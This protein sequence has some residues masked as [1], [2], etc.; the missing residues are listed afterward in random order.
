MFASAVLI[1]ILAQLSPPSAAPARCVAI[2][3]PLHDVQLAFGVSGRIESI[4][5]QRGQRVKAGEIVARLDADDLEANAALL[6]LRADGTW[7]VDAATS[8]WKS[9]DDTL[10]RI[11]AARASSAA[12]DRELEE[13]THRAQQ[14]LAQLNLEK[15]RQLEATWELK[16]ALARQERTV[17]R[18]S[19]A[20]VIEEIR[21]DAGGAVDELASVIRLVDDSAFR[22]EV[23]VPT[24]LTLALRPGQTLE[25]WYR[26]L[27]QSGAPLA[28]R[29]GTVQALAAVAD[30]ASRTRIVHL[31]MANPEGLPAGLAV[32]VLVPVASVITG[33]DSNGGFD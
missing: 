13:A 26:D 3:R 19:V 9:A 11:V 7:S 15:Q 18:A 8:A 22:M 23:A 12:T 20:G 1:A 21:V 14:L 33:V 5:V 30:A 17:M 25:V 27:A 24:E 28:M 6:Q 29:H 32:D 16:S 10:R 4:A 2:T 31:Q